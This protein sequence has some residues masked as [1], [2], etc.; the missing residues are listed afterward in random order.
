MSM[1]TREIILESVEFNPILVKFKHFIMKSLDIEEFNCGVLI[2]ELARNFFE[3]YLSIDN[4]YYDRL[5]NIEFIPCLQ[6]VIA[7][8]DHFI[9]A[10][11]KHLD[12]KCITQPEKIRSFVEMII[13]FV[14]DRVKSEHGDR[15]RV[16]KLMASLRWRYCNGEIDITNNDISKAPSEAITIYLEIYRNLFANRVN[17]LMDFC[18]SAILG[19]LNIGGSYPIAEIVTKMREQTGF[20]IGAG[21]DC[22]TE[23]EF[24][25]FEP[26]TLI[27][28]DRIK[29]ENNSFRAKSA[30]TTK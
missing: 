1:S 22:R 23:I 12:S 5:L 11:E 6:Y 2:G 29:S 19:D 28:L 4:E 21:V 26:H 15:V 7:L 9:G 10:I 27:L 13:L 17:T 16:G 20:S 24:A 25:V 3:K 14:F 18:S 8:E 30:A